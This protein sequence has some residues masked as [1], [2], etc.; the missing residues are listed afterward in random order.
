MIPPL[1]LVIQF[2][3]QWCCIKRFWK[4]APWSPVFLAIYF[5]PGSAASA[6]AQLGSSSVCRSSLYLLPRYSGSSISLVS[7]LMMEIGVQDAQLAQNTFI[8]TS[9][10]EHW[11]KSFDGQVQMRDA[12]R[13]DITP[14]EVLSIPETMYPPCWVILWW[15]VAPNY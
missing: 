3:T 4:S 15:T 11:L 1:C 8:A 14:E 10:Y 2:P 6:W 13:A 9:A 12:G 7:A 5:F